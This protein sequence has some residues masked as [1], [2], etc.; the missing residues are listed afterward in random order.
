[1]DFFFF[2]F[3][4]FFLSF[5]PNGM[6]GRNC[7]AGLC[8]CMVT[9]KNWKMHKDAVSE[10]KK[11]RN[12]DMQRVTDLQLCTLLLFYYSS[13]NYL[14]FNKFIKYTREEEK[15][16]FYALVT[17]LNLLYIMHPKSSPI[18]NVQQ[19]T[20]KVWIGYRFLPK[21]SFSLSHVAFEW[22]Q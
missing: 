17:T 2:L 5:Q 11:S 8:P 1:M 12:T 22:V 10:K 21:S 19:I 14:H 7:V 16:L 15:T 4:G 18:D 20:L 13:N 6:L 3:E 9:S